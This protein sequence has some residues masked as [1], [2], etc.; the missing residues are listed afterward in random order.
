VVAHAQPSYSRPPSSSLPAG[1]NVAG[2]N[3]F[4][5]SGPNFFERLFGGFGQPEPQPIRRGQA[6]QQR[7]VITR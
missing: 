1:V 5:S 7:R 6:Q 2:D 3:G 4:G